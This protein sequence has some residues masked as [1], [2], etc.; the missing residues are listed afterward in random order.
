MTRRLLFHGGTD[1]DTDSLLLILRHAQPLPIPAGM[2]TD[3]ASADSNG[4][5]WPWLYACT[6]KT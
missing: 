2:R 4:L 3:N 5:E 6:M 1:W